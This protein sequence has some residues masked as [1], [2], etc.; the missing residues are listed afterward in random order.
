VKKKKEAPVKEAPAYT[1]TKQA[2]PRKDDAPK[3]DD[4]KATIEELW[5]KGSGGLK[6]TEKRY[7]CIENTKIKYAKKE[8]DLKSAKNF[9]TIELKGAEI[10]AEK[11][12]GGKYWIKIKGHSH[13]EIACKNA[14]TRTKWIALLKAAGGGGGE[15]KPAETKKPAEK[16][17]EETKKPAEKPKEDAKKP[18]PEKKD[19]KKKPEAEK[20]KKKGDKDDE[21]EEDE[22]GDEEEED[23]EEEDEEEE[24]EE[25][26]DEED[27][28]EEDEEDEEEDEEDEEEDDED[29]E[30]DGDS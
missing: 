19:D 30:G 10:A 16:P 26:E 5:K 11:E 12:S 17:K 25:E 22:E 9:K 14:D 28:E 24:D 20:K 15:S 29:E 13:R 6:K 27:E 2:S 23:E 18:A 3:K 7:M 8:S 1:K 4:K 21:E